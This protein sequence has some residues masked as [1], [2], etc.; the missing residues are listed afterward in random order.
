LGRQNNHHPEKSYSV[1]QTC[2]LACCKDTMAIGSHKWPKG[3]TGEARN[4]NSP[5]GK[6]AVK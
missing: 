2:R 5:H 1:P 6:D 3:K 4:R